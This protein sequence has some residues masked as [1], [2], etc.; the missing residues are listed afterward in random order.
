MPVARSGDPPDWGIAALIEDKATWDD[1]LDVLSEKISQPRTLPRIVEKDLYVTEAIRCAIAP[2]ELYPE[3]RTVF[4]GGTSL[5]KAYPILN[6]F[7]EDVDV[8]IIP[9]PNREFGHSRRRK[10]RKELHQRL[11]AGIPLNI[12]HQ[13][14][15]TNYATS[16]IS[17]EPAF[18]TEDAVL[19]VSFGTVLVEMN[20]R[21][22]PKGMYGLREVRSLAG[23]AV[24][25]LDSSLLDQYPLLRPFEVWTADPIIAVVD[26]LDALNWR[27]ASDRP[28]Q[29]AS[30]TRDI[31]DLGRLLSHDLVRPRLNSDLV[32]EMHEIVVNSIPSGLSDRV[33]PRPDGGFADARAFQSGHASH[34]A[35]KSEYPKLRHL[36]YSDDDWIEFEDA[37]AIIRGSS[38]LI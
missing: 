4:K 9:P 25:E 19:G 17:Y 15:G 30:R 11:D 28:E 23:E 33:T 13:R 12:E 18:G 24:A 27:G 16:I 36:I 35:L 1:L 20:I 38:H 34:D 5:A 3:V 37:V 10:A 22:Q 8:N 32:S 29:T 14:E 7:S 2:S 6:R 26:K 31:Y 21:E